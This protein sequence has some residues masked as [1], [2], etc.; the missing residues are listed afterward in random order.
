[1]AICYQGV[2]EKQKQKQQNKRTRS[3]VFYL[4]SLHKFQLKR[5]P[6]MNESHAH[7]QVYFHLSLALGSSHVK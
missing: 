5:E 7:K 4:H 1:M 3:N 2:N 6:R